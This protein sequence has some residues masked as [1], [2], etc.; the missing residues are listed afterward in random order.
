M[1]PELRQRLYDDRLGTIRRLLDHHGAGGALLSLRRN[2]AWATVG[3]EN[4]VMTS[5]E[6]G[7]ASLLVT[8]LDSRVLTGANEASRIQDEE[9]TGLRTDVEV[10][11]WHDAGAL[12]RTARSVA[13]GDIVGDEALEADLRPHR[14]RLAAPE[15][16]RLRWLAE[17]SVVAVLTAL[18]QATAGMTEHEVGALAAERL[19]SDGIRTPVL[20]AAADDRIERYRHPL[21]SGRRVERRLMLVVVAE[22]W[23]LHAAMTR[24]LDLEPPSALLERRMGSVERIH[25]AMVTSTR[26]GRTL[27]EVFAATRAA[28]GR[29]GHPDEWKLHHQGGIIGYQGREAIAVPDDPTIIAEGMAFAWNPSIT[30]AKAEETMLIG[31]NG[32]ELLTAVSSIP[33]GA[34]GQSGPAA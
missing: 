6:N 7:A 12:E 28:Y 5:T 20:L 27:G 13:G 11:P 29:E 2:F 9:L 22:R 24:F 31:P 34:T 17:R 16:D 18:E 3:G 30:G 15:A 4:H 21:P 14:C 1:T 33:E 26:P 8:P 32:P 25:A 10:L 23:G 19:G